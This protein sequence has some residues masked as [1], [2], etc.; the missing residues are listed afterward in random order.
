MRKALALM[1]IILLL[2]LL[3]AQMKPMSEAQ[4]LALNNITVIDMT[5]APPKPNQTLIIT[6]NRIVA[7]GKSGEVSVPQNAFVIDATGKFLIPGLWDMHTHTNWSKPKEVEER[8]FP[9]FIANGV[10]GV[11]EM[12]SLYSVE[13]FDGWRKDSASGK[14]LAPRIVVGKFVDGTGGSSLAFQVKN[15]SEARAAVQRIKREGYDFVKVYKQV[16]IYFVI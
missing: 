15:E 11:R 9:L 13:Q 16:S 4:P 6:G 12:G 3:A 10:T 8:F 2:T 14:L 5:D 7:L 1:L